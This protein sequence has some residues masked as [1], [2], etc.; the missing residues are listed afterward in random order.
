MNP[1]KLYINELA[2]EQ[3]K[4]MDFREMG[5]DEAVGSG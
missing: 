4:K 5:I 1:R 3:P 2:L